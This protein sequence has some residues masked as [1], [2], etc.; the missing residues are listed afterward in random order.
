[1]RAGAFRA[2]L[3]SAFLLLAAA[4]ATAG[5]T[6]HFLDATEL[7][8]HQS[9]G[10]E[11]AHFMPGLDLDSNFGVDFHVFAGSEGGESDIPALG[12]GIDLT[13]RVRGAWSVGL[14]TGSMQSSEGSWWLNLQAAHSWESED[15]LRLTAQLAASLQDVGGGFGLI[16][17]NAA[18]GSAEHYVESL[19]YVHLYEHVALSQQTGFVRWLLDFGYLSSF[20]SLE[21]GTPP[22]GAS[23]PCDDPPEPDFHQFAFGVGL[24]CH[25][26]PLEIAGGVRRRTFSIHL[27]WAH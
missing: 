5:Y 12:I 13:R 14:G 25:F 4:P 3:C 15:D 8:E 9:H 17:E 26:G 18:G 22:F 1:M 6:V 7:A 2:G 23:L 11:T 10:V 27:R 24:G 21:E 20:G 19:R 16:C